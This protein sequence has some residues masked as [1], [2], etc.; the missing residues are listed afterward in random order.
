MKR[1]GSDQLVLGPSSIPADIPIIGFTGSLGSGCTF[2]AEGVRDTHRDCCHYYRL[3]DFLR[4]IAKQRGVRVPNTSQLQDLGNDLRRQEGN[5]ALVKRCLQKI[6]DDNQSN[7]FVQGDDTIILVDG[8]RNDGEVRT[9][10]Q[11]PNFCLISVHAEAETRERR[12]V[13]PEQD[14]RFKNSKSFRE[15]DGRDHRED[16]AYGQQV[17][18]CNYMADVIINNDKDIA[19][20]E[21]RERNE[22]FNRIFNDYIHP[23]RALRQGKQVHD[24]PPSPSETLMTMAYCVSKRSRCLKRKVG[25]VIAYVRPAQRT[26]AQTLGAEQPVEFQVVSSG[27]NDVPLGTKACVFEF[28]KCYRDY[29]QAELAKKFHHCPNCGKRIPIKLKCPHCGTKNA[30]IQSQCVK[31]EEELLPRFTCEECA[32]MI[33]SEYLPGGRDTPGKLLDVCRALH[34]EE[35]AIIRLAG[36]GKASNGELVL[37]TTTFPCNLCANKIVAAGI[38]RVVYAEPYP[39]EESKKVLDAGGVPVQKFEGVKSTAYF[40]LYA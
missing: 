13:G 4:D 28:E 22:Y 35:N 7:R 30:T 15:A 29:L 20:T 25:A 18:Q 11:F 2:L 12:L 27:Y 40:R 10:R 21:T 8:I 39:S 16:V 1:G 6:E 37:Y 38:R 32:C 9:L 26:S 36:I 23:V 31:C 14:K 24:R 34:A 3:S 19:E 5:A 33:F 17:K